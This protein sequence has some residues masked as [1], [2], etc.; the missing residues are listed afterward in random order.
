M[1]RIDPFTSSFMAIIVCLTPS[2]PPGHFQPV[3]LS[4]LSLPHFFFHLLRCR[5][6]CIH[7]Q[8]F[9][10]YFLFTLFPVGIVCLH[11]FVPSSLPAL[12]PFQS[13]FQY[14]RHPPLRV[15]VSLSTFPAASS[16]AFLL[17]FS[18]CFHYFQQ[19]HSFHRCLAVRH[20]KRSLVTRPRPSRYGFMIIT[21]L[22]VFSQRFF[23]PD[24]LPA[25]TLPIYLGLG[26][27][28]RDTEMCLRWLC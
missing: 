25:A 5:I 15:S 8:C 26:P 13:L 23:K 9:S 21:H 28:S 2:S 11:S 4:P 12:S 14:L 24:A 22:Y 6:V 16:L 1:F 3:P 20:L 27:A 19:Q 10:L 18:S 17:S 7:L